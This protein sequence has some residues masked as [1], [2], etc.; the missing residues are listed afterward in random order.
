MPV[1]G[2]FGS[3]TRRLQVLGSR[4]LGLSDER[5][6]RRPGALRPLPALRAPRSR[7]SALLGWRG[8]KET[9]PQLA[10]PLYGIWKIS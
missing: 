5:S 1:L 6:L 7:P 3:A 10:A 4:V 9:H 8:L 2:V